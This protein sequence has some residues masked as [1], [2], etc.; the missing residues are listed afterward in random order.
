MVRD[1]GIIHKDNYPGENETIMASKIITH[2]RPGFQGSDI[3]CRSKQ[4][5]F[6]AQEKRVDVCRTVNDFF[7]FAAVKPIVV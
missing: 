4:F 5:T 2:D 1:F 3:A 7:W 6:Q